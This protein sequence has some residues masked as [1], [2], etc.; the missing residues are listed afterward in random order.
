LGLD[1]VVEKDTTKPFEGNTMRN[2]LRY[3]TLTL[4]AVLALLSSTGDAMGQGVV[5]TEYC[6]P[7]VTY[8]QPAARVVRYEQP[9]VTYYAPRTVYYPSRSISYYEVPTV[10]Y[11]PATSVSYYSAPTMYYPGAVSVTRYGPLGRRWSTRTYY[12]TYV[13]P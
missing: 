2:I 9:V 13:Q 6:P 4:T 7:T 3:L 10:S 1:D 5:V 8:Y 11:Y 12:P